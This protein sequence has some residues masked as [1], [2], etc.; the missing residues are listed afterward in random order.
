[1]TGQGLPEALCHVRGPPALWADTAAI[2]IG[3]DTDL[4]WCVIVLLRCSVAV[5]TH[6]WLTDSRMQLNYSCF[7]DDAKVSQSA[8]FS[9]GIRAA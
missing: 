2:S 4:L 8:M 3:R 5:S 6:P 1:M 7:A 9:T